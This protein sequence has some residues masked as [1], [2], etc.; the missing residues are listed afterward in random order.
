MRCPWRVDITAVVTFVGLLSC[1][2]GT[3]LFGTQFGRF[4]QF[5][6]HACPVTECE[7]QPPCVPDDQ[8]N[9]QQANGCPPVCPTC[10]LQ[11]SDQTTSAPAE[12]RRPPAG[13]PAY[14][15]VGGCTGEVGP[16]LPGCQPPLC[17]FCRDVPHPPRQGSWRWPQANPD[18]DPFHTQTLAPHTVRPYPDNRPK[19]NFTPPPPPTPGPNQRTRP[20]LP[21]NNLPAPDPSPDTVRTRPSSFLWSGSPT[22]FRSFGT[23]TVQHGQDGFSSFGTS[24]AQRGQDGWQS[25][26]G[27]S[28]NRHSD[29]R[30]GQDSFQSPTSFSGSQTFGHNFGG[31]FGFGRG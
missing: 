1:M 16:I 15:C 7:R 18:V 3:H 10:S 14:V 26:G 13:C 25:P 22:G 4:R 23:N 17:P 2:P 9:P 11:Q 19:D 20:P 6:G 27:T 24:T 21:P 5:D 30:T 29:F 31:G 8:P 12:E 28:F